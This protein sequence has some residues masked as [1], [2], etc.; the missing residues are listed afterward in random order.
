MPWF[1]HIRKSTISLS[2]MSFWRYAHICFSARHR[3]SLGCSA[4]EARL[5]RILLRS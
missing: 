1:R 4:H 2:Y 5:A 3:G